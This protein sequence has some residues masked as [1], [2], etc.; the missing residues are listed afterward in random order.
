MISCLMTY[1]PAS[2]ITGAPGLRGSSCSNSEE[3]HRSS[4]SL[5]SS[6][7]VIQCQVNCFPRA[8][9]LLVTPTRHRSLENIG[10]TVSGCLVVRNLRTEAVSSQPWHSSYRWTIAALS[11]LSG[12]GSAMGK[13]SPKD[14]PCPCVLSRRSRGTVS[15]LQVCLDGFSAEGQRQSTLSVYQVFFL[16]FLSGIALTQLVGK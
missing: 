11:S 9:A 13:A 2:C 14:T 5:E 6:L 7:A 12:L 4:F 1:F 10:V 16:A 15:H 3:E 8:E